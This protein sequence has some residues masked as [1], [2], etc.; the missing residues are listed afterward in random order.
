M[1]CLRRSGGSKRRARSGSTR[2]LRAKGAAAVLEQGAA[3]LSRYHRVPALTREGAR[4]HVGDPTL[5][6]YYRNRLDGYGLSIALGMDEIR[7]QAPVGRWHDRAPARSRVLG[8]GNWGTT[9]AQVF[10]R[11]GHATTLWSRDAEQCA[12]INREH[13]NARSLPGHRAAPRHRRDQRSRAS[14]WLRPT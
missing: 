12:E 2:E 10:A 4:L 7:A 11:N 8:A 13:S 14:A 1:R 9:L 5:L 6:L 3:T